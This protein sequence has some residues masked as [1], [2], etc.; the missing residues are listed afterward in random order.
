VGPALTPKLHELAESGKISLRQKEFDE[1][2]LSGEF[3]VIAATDSADVNTHVAQAC[4]KKHVLVNVAAPPGESTFIV[5]SVVER[6]GLMIAVST[7]G[8]SPA[9]AKKI[10]Q[11]LE[12]RYDRAYDLFLEK[13]GSIRKRVMEEVADEQQ[14]R[15]IF[16]RIVDSDAIELLRAGKVHEAEQRMDELAGLKHRS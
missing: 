12:A 2:D 7:S 8:V 13:F 11:E 9:L 15:A 6:G 14:R 10:R 1:H 16:Q 4:R 3:L 5:P